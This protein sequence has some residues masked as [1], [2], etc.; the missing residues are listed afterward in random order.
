MKRARNILKSD[1]LTDF[2]HY[3]FPPSLPPD[4]RLLS[5]LLLA[6]SINLLAFYQESR[7]LIGY[8]THYLF[9]DR[10][11]GVACQCALL[12]NWWPHLG[13]FVVTVKKIPITFSTTSRFIL[14]Q[15]IIRS[16]FLWVIVDSSCAL[17]NYHAVE[18]SS[19]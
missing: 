18:I 8:A 17:V 10:Q 2:C 11:C 9:C 4:Q 12:T 16:R 5:H 6:F 19:S 14:K 15:L 13:V 3:P 1:T 7:S